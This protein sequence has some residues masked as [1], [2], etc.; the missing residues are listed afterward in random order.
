MQVEQIKLDGIVDMLYYFEIKCSV[1]IDTVLF[2][3]INGH[4]TRNGMESNGE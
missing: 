3:E 1:V 4:D 2:A